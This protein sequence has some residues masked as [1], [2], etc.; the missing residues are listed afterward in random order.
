[1]KTTLK[2]ILKHN[3]S[4]QLKQHL[5][6]LKTTTY[7]DFMTIYE[8]IGIKDAI[9]C[10]RVLDYKDYCLF[11]ADVAESVL[12][13]FEAEYP[14]IKEP[15]KAIDGIRA[16]HCGD[17]DTK[18]LRILADVALD[19]AFDDNYGYGYTAG[20]AA[21][22]AAAAYVGAVG[23]VGAAICAG[24]DWEKIEELFIKHFGDR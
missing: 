19:A 14:D 1:M 15:R 22:A 18:E 17:I 2:E 11:L 9:W 13:I 6:L 23:T 24:A 7:I 20:A 4:E 10:L 3:P 8:I 16:W 21:Y 5:S 12:P